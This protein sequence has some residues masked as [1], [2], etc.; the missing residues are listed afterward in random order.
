M[1]SSFTEEEQQNHPLTVQKVEDDPLRA[2]EKKFMG[3]KATE[4]ICPFNAGYEDGAISDALSFEAP[5]QRRSAGI[6]MFISAAQ[7]E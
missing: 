4:E 6:E 1:E 3:T 7:I 2:P 5:E